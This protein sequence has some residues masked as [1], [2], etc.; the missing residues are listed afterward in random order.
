MFVSAFP[1]LG[2]GIVSRQAQYID[3]TVMIVSA[4][5]YSNGHCKS[6]Q[7]V[8][9]SVRALFSQRSHSP[10]QQQHRQ[11]RHLQHTSSQTQHKQLG[12]FCKTQHAQCHC[13]KCIIYNTKEIFKKGGEGHIGFCLQYGGSSKWISLAGIGRDNRRKPLLR[14]G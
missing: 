7:K 13:Q 8:K 11:S 12:Y 1:S 2:L 10:H 5:Y 6:K 9:W 14:G 4:K 3:H